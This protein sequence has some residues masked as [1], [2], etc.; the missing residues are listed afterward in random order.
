MISNIDMLVAIMDGAIIELLKPNIFM[1]PR[2]HNRHQEVVAVIEKILVKSREGSLSEI[3]AKMRFEKS[4]R[5]YREDLLKVNSFSKD[6]V[7]LIVTTSLDSIAEIV[8]MLLDFSLI[9][10]TS[11][12]IGGDF[13]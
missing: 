3:E 5:D 6:K 1:I 13:V 7:D 11:D 4:V 9:G 12:F 10:K 8:N 2:V